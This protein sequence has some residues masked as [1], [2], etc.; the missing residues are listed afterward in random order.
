MCQ[1]SRDRT[2]RQECRKGLEPGPVGL[3]CGKDFRFC[4]KGLKK[5]QTGIS[6]ESRRQ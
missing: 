5:L 6:E 3:R 2:E 1:E 4:S